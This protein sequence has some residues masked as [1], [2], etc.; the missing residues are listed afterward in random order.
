MFSRRGATYAVRAAGRLGR[1][2]FLIVVLAAG[3]ALLLAQDGP[4]EATGTS[5]P[6]AVQLP[7]EFVD[8]L[9]EVDPLI[10]AREKAA[11]LRLHKDYQRHSF[12]RRFWESRDPYPQTPRN[13]LKDRWDERLHF[14]RSAW[15]GLMDDRARVYL[16]HGAPQQAFQV[17]CTTTRIPAEVWIYT[18]SEVVDFSFVLLFARYRGEGPA[19]VYR[20]QA[21][22]ALRTALAD[23]RNCLNG[24]RLT[25]VLAFAESTRGDYELKLTRALAKPKPRSDEWVDTFAAYSTEL[26][27]DARTFDADLDVTFPGR[28]DNRTVTQGVVLIPPAEARVAEFAGHRSYDFL[29]NGEVVLGDQLFESFRYRYGFPAGSGPPGPLP[30]A[31]QRY[32]RPGSYQL[33][34]RIEDLNSGSFY[35]AEHTL[36]VPASDGPEIGERQMDSDTARLFEEATAALAAG[37]TQIR[38]LPPPGDLHSGFVRIATLASGEVARVRFLLDGRPVLTRNRPPFDVE[39]DLGQF[40]RRRV[41]TAEA[42]DGDGAVVA[43]ND[44]ELNGGGNRFGVRLISPQRGTRFTR[45]LEVEA[46]VRLPDGSKLDRLEL[47]LDEH[48]AAT[49]YQEPFLHPLTV[50]EAAGVTYVRA[51][52]YLPDGNSTEDVVFVNAPDFLEKIDVQFVEL[53]ATVLDGAGRPVQ[54]LARDDFRVTE[55]GVPQTIAR[56]ERVENLPIHA[57]ILIDTSGSMARSLGQVRQAALTFLER[58]VKPKDRAAIIT[59]SKFPRLSVKLTSDL[60]A[61]GGGLAGLAPEGE[62]ALYDSLIFSLYYFSGIR[63]QRALLLLSD[64]KDE[65]SR[66]TFEETLEYARRAGVTIFA[67]G[68]KLDSGDARQKL[69]L[70]AQETGGRSFFLENVSELGAIYGSIEEELRSQYLVAYQSS[71]IKGTDDFRAVELLVDLPKAKVNTISGYYP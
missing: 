1:A 43:T 69:H 36:E 33:V 14:A 23:A 37:V 40:P 4:P 29:M 41:L 44:L 66:F 61:L 60:T 32:L 48:L 10:T 71:N 54:D 13:E 59:F 34:V 68:L 70:L 67:I 22:G 53:Y 6:P 57:G 39:L 26:P 27:D 20:P 65:S 24:D 7:Q 56:F 46:E 9:A 51:V 12:I 11:F 30:L 3:S 58:I 31:F 42:L 55:D 64:G 62:T 8:W 35:R 38:I 63:G 50:P 47:Y 16:L 19:R 28:H 21:A 52:A 5:S 17:K 45:S 18:E 49:L 15:G 2:L 25:Q